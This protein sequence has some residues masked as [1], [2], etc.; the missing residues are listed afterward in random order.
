[1]YTNGFDKNKI[2]NL[3]NLYEKTKIVI[4]VKGKNV[5]QI[6]DIIKSDYGKQM[7]DTYKSFCNHDRV[8]FRV[9]EYTKSILNQLDFKNIEKY[10][11]IK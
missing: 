9:N 8:I 6:N 3:L 1:V 11:T 4:D 2:T 5:R 10:V 7:M